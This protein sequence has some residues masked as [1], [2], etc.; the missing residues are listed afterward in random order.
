MDKDESAQLAEEMDLTNAEICPI[1]NSVVVIKKGLRKTKNR[2]KQQKRICIECG[3]NFSGECSYTKRMRLPD[4]ILIRILGNYIHGDSLR[5]IQKQIAELYGI[6]IS[7]VAI[8]DYID[9]FK[10]DN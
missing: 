9:K 1:C 7:H 2:G 4:H 10:K 6:Y 3:T 5:E 8:K